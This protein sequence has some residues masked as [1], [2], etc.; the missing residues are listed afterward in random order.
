MGNIIDQEYNNRK[1]NCNVRS[2]MKDGRCM[3]DGK[4]RRGMVAYE[5]KCKITGK[6]YIGKTQL[7]LKDRTKQ[8]VND[9]WKVIE[10]GR[11]K[12]GPN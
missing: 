5:L 7:Y 8:H 4:Y 12:F 9:I 2:K 1:C 11:K 10:S 3:Y 6:S